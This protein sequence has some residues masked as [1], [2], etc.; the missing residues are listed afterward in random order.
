MPGPIE[1]FIV[2]PNPTEDKL[3]ME[4]SLSASLQLGA[5]LYN[6][7]G[8]LLKKLFTNHFYEKG[9]NSYVCSIAELPQGIYL[10]VVES[11]KGDVITKR[12]IR[13]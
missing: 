1:S 9:T 3:E 13:K 6:V 11:N 10:L 12:I 8:Q 4:F 5:G 7:N 2:Y